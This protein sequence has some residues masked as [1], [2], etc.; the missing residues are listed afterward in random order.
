LARTSRCAMVVVG[1]RKAR[2]ISSVFNPHNVR[3][4]SATCASGPAPD[5]AGEDQAQSLVGHGLFLHDLYAR[6]FGRREHGLLLRE[7][8][9]PPDPIDGVVARRA[10]EPGARIGRPVRCP[11]HQRGGEGLLKRLFGKVEVAEGADE[12][13]EQA[14][15]LRAIKLIEI[16]GHAYAEKVM[17]GRTSIDPWRAPGIFDAMLMAVSRSAASTR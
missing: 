1:T 5:A 9:P 7:A 15:P 4:V 10:V 11:L 8:R 3:S 6:R 12:G 2:A 16:L 14:P 17:I 13:R